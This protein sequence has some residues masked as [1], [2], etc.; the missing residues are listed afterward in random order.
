MEFGKRIAVSSAYSRETLSIYATGKL[1]HH[2]KNWHYIKKIFNK[3][4]KL[5]GDNCGEF[6][7]TALISVLE[8]YNIS[9]EK[10]RKTIKIISSQCSGVL[11]S[12]IQQVNLLFG[13]NKVLGYIMGSHNSR[14]SSIG[15]REHMVDP[16][17][18]LIN[19]HDM[20]SFL[21]FS[22]PKSRPFLN[23]DI[24]RNENASLSIHANKTYYGSL[25]LMDTQI[26]TVANRTKE[27]ARLVGAFGPRG[28]S[29]VSNNAARRILRNTNLVLESPSL[30][31][32]FV[33]YQKY[34][35]SSYLSSMIVIVNNYSI[36]SDRKN[37]PYL[38]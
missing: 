38:Y 20:N 33:G 2:A 3:K 37:N 5:L 27:G 10:I 8:E 31:K 15:T 21:S 29:V 18:W 1:S 12:Y 17:H 24:C 13:I 36:I 9:E 6:L 7:R 16:N 35:L 32:G 19:V 34:C 23:N 25:A 22:K 11:H 26:G 30:R 28:Q 4:M 14:C